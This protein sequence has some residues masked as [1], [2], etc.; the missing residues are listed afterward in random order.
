MFPWKF[1]LEY[2]GT[3]TKLFM[4]VSPHKNNC[5]TKNWFTRH[6]TDRFLNNLCQKCVRA[7][8]SIHACLSFLHEVIIGNHR[9][10]PKVNQSPQQWRG[11]WTVSCRVNQFFVLQLFLCGTHGIYFYFFSSTEHCA[12]AIISPKE[13]KFWV[14]RISFALLYGKTELSAVKYFAICS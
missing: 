7:Y 1:N 14:T 12:W 10:K 9:T 5:K 2:G 11:G 13:F 8:L 3:F 6:E 4:H